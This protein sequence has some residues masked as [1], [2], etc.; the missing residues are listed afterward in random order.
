MQIF[1]PV[2]SYSDEKMKA[3]ARI[4]CLIFPFGGFDIIVFYLLE[5]V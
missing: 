3:G 2:A 1:A 4:C 5:I